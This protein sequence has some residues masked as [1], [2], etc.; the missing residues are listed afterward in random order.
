[1][2]RFQNILVQVDTRR[3][4]LPLFDQ[5]VALAQR[6]QAELK[7]VDVLPDF[8]WPMRLVATDY[9]EIRHALIKEKTEAVE[10]MAE[11]A[12]AS[13]V[14]ATAKVLC[15]KSSDQIVAE[16]VRFQ[17]DLVIKDAKG[18][19]SHHPGTFGTTAM[20]LVRYCPCPVWAFRPR[21]SRQGD[22]VVAA[23]DASSANDAHLVLNQDILHCAVALLDGQ[24]PDVAHVWSVYGE[25]L[26]K[27]YM[28][29]EEFGALVAD[30]RNRARDD[31]QRV[32]DPFQVSADDP[33]VHLLRGDACEELI[34]CVN[35]GGYDVLVLGTVARTGL[36]GLLIGNTAEALINRVEC[37]VLAV[38]PSGFVTPLQV[39]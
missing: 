39:A 3:D 1:M 33:R 21:R 32:L 14:R 31:V 2:K 36:S 11:Q 37:S 29:R 18:Q 12:K 15:G 4:E 6:H 7:I 24:F 10:R 27:D 34:R 28:K 30:A 20:R 9:N 19:F 26:I 38:K 35:Q 17:H 13:G 5:A 16:V 8:S 25:H 22:R 23:I